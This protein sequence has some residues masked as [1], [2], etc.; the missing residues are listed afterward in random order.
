MIN[1]QPYSNPRY[2]VILFVALLPLIIGL[3][4]G[5]RFKIYE[6]LVSL[7]FLFLMFDGQDA[8]QGYQFIGYIIFQFLLTIAYWKYIKSGK[9][10]TWV[11]CLVIIL[12]IL[13]LVVVKIAPH[14]PDPTADLIGF[15][16]VSYLTFKTVQVLMELRD[17]TLKKVDP[18]TYAR[19]L[20]FF[21]TISSGPIDRYKRFA[22]DYNK[23]SRKR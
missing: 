21:P 5:R 8:I 1:L 14:I 10:Q 20:L 22:Q 15:F 18:I 2:F 17:H 7:L 3:Y 19:F 11:F 23:S 6:A 4:F 13:P 16:G 12:S 9:N